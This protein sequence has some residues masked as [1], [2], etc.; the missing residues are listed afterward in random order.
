MKAIYTV[1]YRVGGTPGDGETEAFI[2]KADAIKRFNWWVEQVLGRLPSRAYEYTA[3]DD[4]ESEVAESLTKDGFTDHEIEDLHHL[5]YVPESGVSW[6]WDGST[7]GNVEIDKHEIPSEHRQFCSW[8]VADVEH[9][10]KEMKTEDEDNFKFKLV[11]GKEYTE[12]FGLKVMEVVDGDMDG[13]YG[14][15]WYS[16][17]N[18][19]EEL[20]GELEITYP[21]KEGDDYYTIEDDVVTWSCWDDQSEEMHDKN[22]NK[23]YFLTREDAANNKPIS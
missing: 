11:Q 10:F 15:N 22:P 19:I 16:I 21:F 18:A 9:K 5:Y 12:E 14:V 8:T 7:W 4:D 17:E 20:I 1:S 13:E 3:D 23:V 6:D 2:N